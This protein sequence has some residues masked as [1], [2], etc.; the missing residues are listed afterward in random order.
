MQWYIAKMV[1][2]IV[3]G[4]G[5]HAAQFD[6]QLR[7]IAANNEEE[8]FGKAYK[9]GKEEEES[10]LNQKKEPVRWQF[11]NVPELYRLGKLTDGTEIYSHINEVDDAEAYTTFVNCKA[12]SIREKQTHLLL[13]LI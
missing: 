8:A 13:N 10:F 6:E 7:L 5:N 3:C 4:D 9:I 12:A 2:Q 1:Y 11:V